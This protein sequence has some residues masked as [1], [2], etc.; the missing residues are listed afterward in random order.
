MEA[1]V[2]I[3]V[4]ELE[5]DCE[6]SEEFLR[7]ELPKI[8]GAIEQLRENAPAPRTPKGGAGSLKHE[9]SLPPNKMTT[10]TLAAKLKCK[11][12]PELVLAAAAKLTICDQQSTFS[13]NDLI[14]EMKSAT[15]FFKASYINNLSNSLSTLVKDQQLHEVSP[16]T[17]SLPDNVKT[18][19]EQKL[20]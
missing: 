14:T 3:R 4:D 18:E 11:K 17:Y 19:L 9:K 10:T 7:Q 8:L 5:V 6:G 20:G 15:G 16:N 2:H 13:R 12:G 1:K